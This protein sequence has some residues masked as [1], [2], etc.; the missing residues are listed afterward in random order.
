[1]IE[2]SIESVIKI[3]PETLLATA[4]G[5]DHERSIGERI[6]LSV[7]MHFYRTVFNA[8]FGQRLTVA[9]RMN[10]GNGKGQNPAGLVKFTVTESLFGRLMLRLK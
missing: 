6:W 10:A 2:Y 8:D 5:P 4:P 7:L 9:G 3:G 1:M